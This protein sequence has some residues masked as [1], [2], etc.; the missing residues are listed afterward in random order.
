M[1]YVK[2]GSGCRWLGVLTV[3][4]LV[5]LSTLGAG[6]QRQRDFSRTDL[7][8][9]F[10]GT[11]YSPWLIGAV[12]RIADSQEI[13]RF[14]SLRS[15][16]EAERFIEDFWGRRA[17]PGEEVNAFRDLFE[18]RAAEAD[19]KFSERHF[20]GRRTDR[21]AVH[22]LYGPPETLEYEE[23]RDISEPDIE[24]WRYSKKAAKGLD[25]RKPERVYRFARQED[26]T[27]IYEP[28]SRDELRR[29][30]RSRP[31]F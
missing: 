7:I 8:Q 23:F 6:A 11:R 4:T 2:N 12:W 21:G 30:A 10:L 25:G 26:V 17:K 19:D 20:L 14:L 18:R 5:A 3:S 1:V 22:I 9:P 13:E 27:R 15:D 16:E 31:P 24:L 28:P 29:R